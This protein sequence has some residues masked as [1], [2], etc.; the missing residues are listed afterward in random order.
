MFHLRIVDFTLH[1]V[2]EYVNLDAKNQ[3]TVNLKKNVL[4]HP[5]WG[6]GTF[7]SSNKSLSIK[8]KIIN[9]MYRLVMATG[10]SR[11]GKSREVPGRSRERTGPRYLE[12]PVV[13]WSRD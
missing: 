5:T 6:L 10:L 11:P 8:L 3:N 12:G 13:L 1:L 7:F 4:F 9:I 2:M